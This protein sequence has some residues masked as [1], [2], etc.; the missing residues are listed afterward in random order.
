MLGGHSITLQQ[1]IYLARLEVLQ[2]RCANPVT[3]SVDLVLG[4][5]LGFSHGFA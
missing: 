1:L 3:I 5:R 2:K 4:S